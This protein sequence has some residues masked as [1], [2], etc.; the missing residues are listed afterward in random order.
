V[1]AGVCLLSK[2]SQ[3]KQDA[4]QAG[5][6]K[7][8][9]Q[10]VSIYEKILELEKNNPTVVNEMGDLCLKTG[11]AS[12]AIS[13][14]LKAAANY[15]KTGLL[16][17]A[18]AIYKKILRHDPENLNAHWFLAATR[19]SQGL[20]HEGELH[21]V[22]FLTNSEE[23][24]GELKEIFLGRCRELFELY[25]DSSTILE[26]LLKIF[27]SWEMNLEASRTLCLLASM[28]FDGGNE[29]EAKQAVADVLERTPEIQNYPEYIKWAKKTNPQPEDSPQF[30]DFGSV[31]F[32]ENQAPEEPESP[33]P[34]APVQPANP[35]PAPAAK[36]TDEASFG[37]LS[38]GGEAEVAPA[39]AADPAGPDLDD[40]GCFTLDADEGASL[41]DL[42][43]QAAQ[44][45]DAP[46]PEAEAETPTLVLDDEPAAGTQDQ[47]G[48]PESKEDFSLSGDVDLLAEI[49]AEDSG[50]SGV[51]DENQLDTI[52]REIGDQMGG[53]EDADDAGRQYEMG[54]VYLEMGLFD[55]AC[56]SLEKA[57]A[58][59][60]FT[61]RAFEMWG[62]GLTRAGRL[63]DAVAVLTQGLEK[64]G[65]GTQESLGLLYNIGRAHEQ[66]GRQD[67]AVACYEKI[68]GQD[69]SFLDVGKRM[70]SLLAL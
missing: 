23:V 60:D 32:D 34:A 65:E 7:D 69:R 17:N 61:V 19:A 20:V 16:N 67:E 3:L 26:H 40:D 21:G 58:D 68:Q 12:R 66:A 25:P 9:D 27:R 28:Q 39:A 47:P 63:D 5:K 52:T 30:S 51:G 37:D 54:L 14:F 4:Y 2:L 35:A 55:Q 70:S 59:P 62:I 29:E 64:V 57:T 11:E 10:A 41:D 36:V 33:A 53:D 43:A 6:K 15:R 18:V 46:E 44:E 31:S 8:W 42:V 22:K 56:E 45:V 50:D 13:H 24:S 48:E 38:L 49:L 1:F